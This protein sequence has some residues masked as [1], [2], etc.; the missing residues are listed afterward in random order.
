MCIRDRCLVSGAIKRVDWDDAHPDGHITVFPEPP[1]KWHL[2]RDVQY[3]GTSLFTNMVNNQMRG[4]LIWLEG[5]AENEYSLM[6]RDTSTNDGAEIRQSL[7]LWSDDNS[8]WELE[9]SN[10]STDTLG[11]TDVKPV[12]PVKLSSAYS[13]RVSG[14][15]LITAQCDTDTS[16]QIAGYPFGSTLDD[17]ATGLDRTQTYGTS[18][19]DNF[20]ISTYDDRHWYTAY[21]L[22]LIHISEPTRPY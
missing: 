12:A 9:D 18:A 16:K 7:Y 22:S 5:E 20:T 3:T 1:G 4:D 13:G 19:P 15:A 10:T 6:F 2:T 11:A 17:V 14:V 21:R 8:R